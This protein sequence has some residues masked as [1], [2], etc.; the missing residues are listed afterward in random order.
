METNLADRKEASPMCFIR[1]Y[2]RASTDE[3]N[4]ARARRQVETFA[5][6]AYD[7]GAS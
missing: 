7:N 4:A 3:Q 6:R 5:A 1:A 2:L